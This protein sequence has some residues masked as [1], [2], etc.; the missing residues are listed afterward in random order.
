MSHIYTNND[1]QGGT[2]LNNRVNFENL[3]A[4]VYFNLSNIEDKVDLSFHY[5]LSGQP[6]ADYTIYAIVLHEKLYSS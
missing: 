6:N 3:F 1:F 5:E 4:F 2:L